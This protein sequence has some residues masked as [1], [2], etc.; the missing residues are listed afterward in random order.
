MVSHNGPNEIIFHIFGKYSSEL[1]ELCIEC[2]II[3]VYWQYFVLL[4]C[5]SVSQVVNEML[6]LSM[7]V[8]SILIRKENVLVRH[9]K[10]LHLKIFAF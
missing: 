10:E 4:F 5:G 2:A 6:R 9:L 1:K 8:D 7:V 3:S